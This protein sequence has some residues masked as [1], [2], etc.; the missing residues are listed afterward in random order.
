MF[1]ETEITV[2]E[3]VLLQ[4]GVCVMSLDVFDLKELQSRFIQRRRGRI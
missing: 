4:F 2:M 3:V 1:N